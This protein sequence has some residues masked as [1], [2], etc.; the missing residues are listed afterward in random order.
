MSTYAV[1]NKFTDLSEQNK[2]ENKKHLSI[3]ISKRKTIN[4][5]A[6]EFVKEESI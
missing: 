3:K 1:Q 4:F 6:K 2:I 5:L